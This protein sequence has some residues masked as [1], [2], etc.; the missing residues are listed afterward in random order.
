[1]PQLQLLLRWQPQVG[2][3]MNRFRCCALWASNAP[4]LSVACRLLSGTL[5]AQLSTSRMVSLQ[6][7]YHLPVGQHQHQHLHRLQGRQLEHLPL[8]LLLSQQCHHQG[9]EEEQLDLCLQLWRSS[10]T[11]HSLHNWLVWWPRI[12]GCWNKCCLPSN[13]ATLKLCRQFSRTLRLS[14]RCCRRLVDLAAELT[15]LLP[16]LLLVEAEVPQQVV[17]AVRWRSSPRLFKQTQQ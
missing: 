1:M 2:K 6:E 5:I 15:L 14:C 10:G 13:R 9:Q 7:S 4:R 11:T 8:S 16:C 12:L 3:W 17:L